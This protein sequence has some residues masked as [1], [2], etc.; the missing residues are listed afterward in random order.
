MKG[1]IQFQIDPVAFPPLAVQD[2]VAAGKRPFYRLAVDGE[3]G[4]FG[5]AGNTQMEGKPLRLI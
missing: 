3:R 1:H 5:P 2:D 4:L